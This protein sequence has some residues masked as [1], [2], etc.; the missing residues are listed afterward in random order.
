M[1]IKNYYSPR[2]A[3]GARRTYFNAKDARE[4]KDAKGNYKDDVLA[5]IRRLR[6]SWAQL[7][8]III[9]LCLRAYN[10]IIKIGCPRFR[11]NAILT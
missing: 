3:E 10:C 7:L 8:I 5:E 4:A 1:F 6:S 2:R 11:P 9:D